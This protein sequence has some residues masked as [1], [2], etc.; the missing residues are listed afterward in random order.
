MYKINISLLLLVL[1]VQP[2]IVSANLD[3]TKQLSEVTERNNTTT[4]SI[5]RAVPKNVG[6][7]GTSSKLIKVEYVT[8]E[9]I[10]KFKDS[11]VSLKNATGRRMVSNLAKNEALE[12][13]ESLNAT[14]I[15]LLKIKGSDTVEEVIKSLEKNPDVEY[16]QPN[17]Q[18]QSLSIGTNDTRG[19][20]LWGLQ[21]LGQ[22][23]GGVNSTADSDI[24]APEAWAINE[25]TSANVIVAVIDNGVAYNHPD[26]KPNMWNGANCVSDTGATLGGCIH[27]Y[28]FED[29]DKDPLSY[30]DHGTHIAGTIAAVKSNS[31]GVAGVAPRAKIMALKSSLTTLENVKAINFAKSNGAKVLNASWGC[32][33][34]CSGKD[35]ALYNAISDF[36]GLFIAAAGNDSQDH[37]SG[38]PDTTM[39]P[40]GFRTNSPA[41]PGLVNIIVVAATDQNDTLADFS[42]YG[43]QSVDVGAPGVNILSTVPSF[44]DVVSENFQSVIASN[45]PSG[46]TK[47]GTNNNWGTYMYP[48]G[49]KVLYGEL[50]APYNNDANT[51]VTSPK[52]NLASPSASISFLAQCDTEYTLTDWFDYMALEVSG[53]NGATFVELDRWD[54]TTLDLISGENPLDE[55]GSASA[56]LNIKIPSEF[57]TKDF[58]Y[59]FRWVTDSSIV[60]DDGC[61]VDN[62]QITTTSD[63]SDNQY[64]LLQ[65]TSFAVPHVAGLAALL[66]GYNPSLSSSEVR[67]IIFTT[68][69]TLPSLVGKTTTGK[70]INAY[71]AML[72]A[73]SVTDLNLT[74][75]ANNPDASTLAVDADSRTEYMVFVFDTESNG[76]DIEIASLPIRIETSSSTYDQVVSDVSIEIDGTRY[77]SDSVV[78]INSTST[79]VSF[80]FLPN[81]FVINGD[82][83][84]TVE[85]F[86]EFNAQSGNYSNGETIQ[87]SLA[88]GDVSGIVA[89]GDDSITGSVQGE[90][91]TLMSEGLYVEGTNWSIDVTNFDNASDIG[92]FTIE[93][94]ATA[95]ENDFYIGGADTAISYHY[96]DGQNTVVST[97]PGARVLSSTADEVLS[98]VY[99]VQEGETE[100]F[101]FT[102]VFTPPQTGQYRMHLDS[103]T[104]GLAPENLQ[105]TVLMFSPIDDFMTGYEY[106]SGPSQ[107]D[108]IPPVITLNGSNPLNLT[109]G[110]TYVEPGATAEDD[111]DGSIT[112]VPSGSVNTAVADTYIITYTATDA[113]GNE[114][115]TTRS[116]IVSEEVV[117][118]D[119]TPPVITLNGADPLNLTVGDTYVEP[120]A[121][122]EDGIDGTVTATPSGSVDT[123]TADIYVV[124]YSASDSA[125]NQST[126]TRDVIVSEPVDTIA[127]VI[128]LI[129]EYIIDLAL[130]DL[131]SEPGYTA[132]DDFDGDI[133][134]SVVV[135]GDTVDTSVPDTYTVTYN[136]TDDAGNPALE[137][138]RVVNVSDADAPIINDDVPASYNMEATSPSGATLSYSPPTATDDIDGEVAVT[139]LPESGTT[140][141]VGPHTIECTASDSSDNDATTS[142]IVTVVDTT[143][144]VITLD[145]ADTLNLTVGDT[146]NESGGTAEDIVDGSVAVA[147]SGSVNTGVAD[148]YIIT[149]SAT[150]V[151]GNEATT[152]RDVIVSEE[153]I[154]PDTI[155]PVIILN[156]SNPLNLTVGDT[157]V[158]PGATAEDNVD[159]PVTVSLSGSVN[160]AVADTYIIT[161]TAGDVAGNE[162]STTRSVVVSEPAPAPSSSGGGGGGSSR[163]RVS[164]E[165]DTA[166]LVLGISTTTTPFA[167]LSEEE[168]KIELQKQLIMLLTQLISLLQQKILAE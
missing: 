102:D 47:S 145:G 113:A 13:V 19:S 94:E 131:Y 135:G 157:Y 127:P 20:E 29:D 121:T 125:G 16:A 54:E 111:I 59:Q 158:E 168:K 100:T 81:E 77:D 72:A 69:D 154:V 156:G 84:S 35:Q 18:Y 105:E 123:S 83:S 42:D 116:V 49:N 152:T 119:T 7:V 38:N 163:N 136:V 149:Y 8:D 114:A 24:D 34:E 53:N 3:Y 14:N 73:T 151:A 144:P 142:F 71:N 15:A 28:D 101:T 107:T 37:N 137:L 167:E 92:E 115:S 75:S 161:Y 85:V 58:K 80:S 90:Q 76:G 25:G 17:F 32:Y 74:N 146:Y 93:F 1:L 44:V 79:I 2:V 68:G 148:T 117:V 103:I 78:D 36:S 124:T 41:G 31:I 166:E 61:L 9:V 87:A 129:G 21:N 88:N 22:S 140:L 96:F 108:I 60:A 160:T 63:G 30:S 99:E 97:S 162:A 4:E 86:V 48:D 126:T 143:P 120:G 91:H 134:E 23:V 66:S 40:A 106:L 141:A 130:D 118:P 50:M 26:L 139:C 57:L 27:G 104:Y 155:A 159:G 56:E 165:V 138:T 95:F 67:N 51:T 147:P 82:S 109:V 64:E 6:G 70:R 62:V 110:D 52:I 128:E 153:V 33:G 133:S 39:Y 55:I 98:G 11:Q 10:V 132:T 122:A 5:I 46:W 112:V 65:G 164:E 12:Q 45:L 43:A 150:D 89:T